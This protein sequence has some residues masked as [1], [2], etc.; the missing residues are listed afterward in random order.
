MGWLH[1]ISKLEMYPIKLYDQ[2]LFPR[3][4][5][6]S[7]RKHLLSASS[8]PLQINHP[9][10]DTQSDLNL[11]QRLYLRFDSYY[12]D[13]SS[14]VFLILQNLIQSKNKKRFDDFDQF[15]QRFKRQSWAIKKW[16][17]FVFIVSLLLFILMSHIQ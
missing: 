4:R 16:I 6:Y 8:A 13:S 3:T 1:T 9:H 17:R 10:H 5:F 14:N 11:L 2:E 7:H 12:H 15:F